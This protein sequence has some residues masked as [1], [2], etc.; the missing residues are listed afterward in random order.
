MDLGFVGLGAMGR[1]MAANLLAA[2]HRVR[3]WNRSRP[4]VDELA[5]RGAEPAG[6]PAE[7]AAA[8]VVISM[9]AD[10][11]AVRD[12]V[13]GRLLPAARAGTVH[14]N[15]ATVSVALARELAEAHR[16]RGVDY[17]AAP[18]FGRPDVAAAGKLTIAAAGPAAAL[19]RVQPLLDAVGQR[20]WRVGEAPY[21]ANVVKLAGNMMLAAA[22]EAMA[23][24]AALGRAHG[25]APAELL[26]MLT[27]SVF[28][29]PVY[30]NYGG[31][32]AA[33]R[34]DPPGFR[35]ALGL[36]DVRLALAAGDDAGVPLPLASLL[37]DALLDAVAHGD[38]AR[39]LAAL[40]A[41]ARRRAGDAGGAGGA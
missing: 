34:Y 36:K 3:V 29:N 28:A 2:G 11:A 15:M 5:A 32:I 37:R 20:T 14:V 8:D 27:G 10:D 22:I 1:A 19:D 40:G 13:L 23:E 6:E 21:R 18:V 9:L 38:G 17:V 31:L 41:V 35:L 25:V 12:V 16:A 26:G 30:A 39:D 4:P 24:A 7:V 33:G